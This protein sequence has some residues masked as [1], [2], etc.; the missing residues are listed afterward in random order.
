[1]ATVEGSG[2][3][4]IATLSKRLLPPEVDAPETVSRR[5]PFVAPSRAVMMGDVTT[6]L[7]A[8]LEAGVLVKNGV[9]VDAFVLYAQVCE[10][11]PVPVP[12]VA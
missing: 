7:K 12:W 3:E 4:T 9:Q 6:P 8:K 1:M 2:T 10:L 5:N 11:K